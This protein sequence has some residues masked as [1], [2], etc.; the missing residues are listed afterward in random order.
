MSW[1]FLRK[2]PYCGLDF[3]EERGKRTPRRSEQVQLLLVAVLIGCVLVSEELG[4]LLWHQ[5]HGI[6]ELFKAVD[7]VTLDA[8]PIPLGKVISSQVAIGF[9]GA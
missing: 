5:R 2:S 1:R 4:G 9:L 7:M 8:P 6:A 3:K